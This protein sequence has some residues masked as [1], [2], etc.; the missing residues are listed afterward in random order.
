MLVEDGSGLFDFDGFKFILGAE[1]SSI[2]SQGG[3]LRRI[4]SLIYTPDLESAEKINKELLKRGAK[5]AS[6]GRPVVGL[7]VRNLLE[8]ILEANEDSI[9]IPA[10]AWTPWF[11]L[12]GTNS[13]FDSIKEAFGDL[14]KY[15]YG[16]ETGL[17][18]NPE[19]NWRVRD[20]DQRSI[21]SFSD[22]HSSAKMGREVTIFQEELS[23]R[24]LLRALKNQKIERTLEFFPEEGK[25]HFTGHRAC[26]I[27]HSPHETAK[28][29]LICPRCGKPLT[30]GVM[31][32]LSQLAE[33]NRPE[34][35]SDPQR[36]GFQMMV[37]LLEILAEVL[38]SPPASKKV[39]QDYQN[40]IKEFK[41]ELNIL[42]EVKEG[43]LEKNHSPR[44]AQAIA[45]VRK[46]EIVI[47]PG[48]DGIFGVVQIWPDERVVKKKIEAQRQKITAKEETNQISLFD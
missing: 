36:P 20:L 34:G 33:Q 38:G 37:P 28:L 10:H 40:L 27:R 22:A 29:G 44:L 39:M 14:E 4:H 32:R 41:N 9:L 24:G 43:E 26:F 48:Y 5:L 17:S 25:Y 18:S 15:V 47:E 19:M 3:K 16:I 42:F 35:F 12:Y 7:S 23:Y 45:K 2:F 1:L 21:V 31:H 46:G 13:G 8:I 11:G 30:I 6:D